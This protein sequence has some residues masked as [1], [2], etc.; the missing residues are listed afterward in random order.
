M[1]KS[2]KDCVIDAVQNIV[3]M[4][5]LNETVEVSYDNL[6]FWDENASHG[7]IVIWT[8]NAPWDER[9][10]ILI[11]GGRLF[12]RSERYAPRSACLAELFSDGENYPTD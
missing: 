8:G 5:F 4:R 1:S 6:E 3:D 12:W 9:I 11:S 10:I 2:L 7:D